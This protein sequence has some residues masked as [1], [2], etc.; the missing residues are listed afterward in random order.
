[1]PPSGWSRSHAKKFRSSVLRHLRLS[2]RSPTISCT[3]AVSKSSP[4]SPG[5]TQMTP[6]IFFA[7]DQ[8]QSPSALRIPFQPPSST[9]ATKSPVIMAGANPTADR[10]G[11]SI[12]LI[13][14]HRCLATC[15]SDDHRHSTC[16]ELTDYPG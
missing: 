14:C 6:I 16:A 12:G 13:F 4:A 10:Q 11:N 2:L 3:A 9:D 7:P 8:T 5:I 1:M 15:Q